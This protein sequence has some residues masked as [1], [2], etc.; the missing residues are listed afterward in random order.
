MELYYSSERLHIAPALG[1]IP[2]DQLTTLQVQKF[3]YQLQAEK[4][5][6]TRTVS[7]IRGALIQMYD[8][9]I[10]MQLVENNPARNAKLPK[11]PRMV[12]DEKEKVIS[13]AQREAL[14]KA[15]AND[16]IM[17]PPVTMLMLTGMR[18]GE[19]LALQWKHVDFQAKTITIQQSLTRELVLTRTAGP[20]A[21]R[22][23]WG[24]RKLALPS[25][26]SKRRTWFWTG[27][28][29]G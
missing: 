3:L 14:L 18:V 9:A 25:G 20:K 11:Q 17:G 22:M 29:N 21:A 5:L 4:Q 23:P 19:M 6:S 16:P 7:L 2:L 27:C 28:G 15:A 26:S 1:H 8:H 10:D 12:R 13:I 24:L